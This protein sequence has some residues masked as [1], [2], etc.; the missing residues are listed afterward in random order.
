MGAPA[1]MKKRTYWHLEALASRPDA[2]T[3]A[4]GTDLGVFVTLDGGLNLMGSPL[5]LQNLTRSW[6]AQPSDS[7]PAAAPVPESRLSDVKSPGIL[8]R[9]DHVIIDEAHNLVDRSREY[10]SPELAS[11]LLERAR[12]YSWED[13]AREL[14]A[15]ARR[16]LTR[17][18]PV[19]MKP[20]SKVVVELDGASPLNATRAVIWLHESTVPVPVG[21]PPAWSCT[22]PSWCRFPILSSGFEEE[23][24]LL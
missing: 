18:R 5:S 7:A 21:F 6:F 1:K 12:A 2:V 4:G 13:S 9:Y 23:L 20:R 16:M 17:S 14:L 19:S 22:P 15:V 3:I 8:P 11:S 10:H 24:R